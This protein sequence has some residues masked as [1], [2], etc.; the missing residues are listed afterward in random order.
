M[1][2]VVFAN[3]WI[4]VYSTFLDIRYRPDI[5]TGYSVF[6]IILSNA[7]EENNYLI[8]PFSFC[9]Q[10]YFFLYIFLVLEFKKKGFDRISRR[11]SGF[12]GYP[13]IGKCDRDR[14]SGIRL[15][16][17]IRV[18]IHLMLGS[19]WVTQ[20]LPQICSANHAIFPIRK[21]K[22]TVQICGN[23]PVYMNP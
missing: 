5:W 17:R 20:K 6:L 3:I 16:P 21:R 14:M 7:L 8:I 19:Y 9:F 1:Y 10:S 23:F 15:L 2:S 13:V 11:F 18:G 4:D 22:I 12:A